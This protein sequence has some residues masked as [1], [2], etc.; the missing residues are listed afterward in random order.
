MGIITFADARPGLACEPIPPFLMAMLH[1][2]GLL[3]HLERRMKEK[4]T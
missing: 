2:G 4:A 1:D 3:P